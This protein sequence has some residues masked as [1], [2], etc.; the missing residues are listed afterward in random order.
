MLA[1][2]LEIVDR[3]Y[4]VQAVYAIFFLRTN[5]KLYR[6]LMIQQRCLRPGKGGW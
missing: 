1:K 4:E 5:N 6:C 2:F 3:K